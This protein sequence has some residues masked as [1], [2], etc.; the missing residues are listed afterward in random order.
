MAN[1]ERASAIHYAR[2][3]GS[4]IREYRE[5]KG[6]T[7]RDLAGRL[8]VFAREISRLESGE[9]QPSFLRL[10]DLSELFGVDVGDLLEK[11][12]SQVRGLGPRLRTAHRLCGLGSREAMA[13]LFEI[14]LGLMELDERRMEALVG[15]LELVE[16]A[17]RLRQKR[18]TRRAAL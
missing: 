12:S 3:I 9:S 17:S 6:W 11:D 14:I 13:A 15:A 18:E 16:G 10:V 8:D 1:R 5:A 7:Q 4:R 2:R